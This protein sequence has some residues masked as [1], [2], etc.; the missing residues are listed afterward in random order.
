MPCLVE[1]P[2]HSGT[3][4]PHTEDGGDLCIWTSGVALEIQ[5]ERL[6]LFTALAFPI[7]LVY[8]VY[9]LVLGDP[10]AITC[11]FTTLMIITVS[12]VMDR[13]L[14]Y[15][16]AASHL[17]LLS[18]FIQ[19]YGAS[20]SDGQLQ[21]A[22]LWLLPL[23]P[24]AATFLISIRAAIIWT[25]VCSLAIFHCAF[26]QAQ[27]AREAIYPDSNVHF[28]L[29]RI[30]GLILTSSFGLVVNKSS[31][32]A[33]IAQ[34][35]HTREL[36]Q[37]KIAAERSNRAKTAFLAQAS[38]EIRTPMNGIL[39]M[40]QHLR[41]SR[42]L[43]SAAREHIQSI[44]TCSESLLT[45]L[46]D[47]LDLSR[48]ESGDWTL[49][50]GPVDLVN[51][52]EEVT[53]LFRTKAVVRGQKLVFSHPQESLWI[54]SDSTRLRQVISN[55]LGNAVKFCEHGDIE[56][57]LWVDPGNHQVPGQKL[58]LRIAVKDQGIGMSNDQLN[59]LFSEFEQM[60]L[61]D[62]V[63]RGGTGLGLAIS[64]QL[65]AKMGGDIDVKSRLGV[66]STFTV[67]LSATI[68]S[69]TTQAPTSRATLPLPGEQQARS[70]GRNVLV[71]DDLPLNRRVATLALKRLGYQSKEAQ[72]GVI[73]FEMAQAEHFDL[74]L[75][76][77]RMP[78]MGG[79][80][81]TTKIMSTPGPNQ[82]TPIVALTASAYDEDRLACKEAGMVDHL[83]KPFR[84]EQLSELL[85]RY[86]SGEQASHE[87]P[88]P[89]PH[90]RGAQ[91]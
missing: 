70:P 57:A 47:V 49:K 6:R 16:P 91:A 88:P 31:S 32:N 7:V 5:R 8:V 90:A 33:L 18:G 60:S 50:Y 69:P 1:G 78:N 65:V 67:I 66:G 61:L 22:G 23:V 53:T 59:A 14:G 46:R 54:Y 56:L 36:E 21:S 26:D 28:F 43:S 12:L 83:S 80:E 42:G 35:N 55:L 29:L 17:L 63:Q 85:E 64:R 74:I 51:L 39:G 10:I 68:C 77:L 75:M 20:F 76:D 27:A 30:F 86:T 13:L 44:E 19:L 3:E 11:N 34:Q 58:D 40:I 24:M 15:V 72:D 9:A 41:E 71:V 81:A 45:I 2:S 84:I 38:H 89:L 79:L 52:L 37:T 4:H 48:V 82:S 62:G 73:A 87:Q 25:I